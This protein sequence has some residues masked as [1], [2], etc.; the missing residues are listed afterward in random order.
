VQCSIDG[1][2][3][4][5]NKLSASGGATGIVGI[6]LRP[7]LD[8]DG[9]DQCQIL[10]N[11]IAGYSE[12][13]ILVRSQVRALIVKLNI[14]E[15]CGNGIVMLDDAEAASVAIENNQLREIG[16]AGNPNVPVTVVGIG[17]S[18]VEGATI[19]GNTLRQ[20]GAATGNATLRA[21]VMALA[22]TRLRVH[23]NEVFELG[24]AADFSGTTIGVYVAGPYLQL[25][26]QHNQIERDALPNEAPG[27]S[28]WVA[29]F[30]AAAAAAGAATSGVLG[31][32]RF[33]RYS[34]VPFENNATLVLNGSKGL[35][36]AG[37]ASGSVAAVLGNT[38]SARSSAP[39]VALRAERECLFSDNRCDH[40][41]EGGVVAVGLQTNLAIVST[42]RVRNTTDIAISIELAKTIVAVGNVTTGIIQAPAM[43]TQFAPLN[44]RA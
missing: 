7:G 12:A 4:G 39:L 36:A 22:T 41:G 27:R 44:L 2:W 32:Q 17:L 18:R 30:A 19:A 20:V 14:I 34:V 3:I 23:G 13:G 1:L 6:E 42:N 9:A 28:S 24:P 29:L 25:E 35:V 16:P 33:G 40:R 26:V 8:K 10:A 11:Q 5:E 31:P 37:F 38:F 43:P 15:A 21:G